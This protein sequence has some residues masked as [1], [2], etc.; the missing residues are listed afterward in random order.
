MELN[1]PKC[2]HDFDAVVWHDGEC[3]SCGNA[4]TWDEQ[5]T[6]DYSDCWAVTEWDTWSSAL[7]GQ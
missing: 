5:C 6:P 3:P 1:C 2:S 4:Y 7:G